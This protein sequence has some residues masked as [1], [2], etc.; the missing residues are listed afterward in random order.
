ML[1][2][3]PCF[4]GRSQHD[5]SCGWHYTRDLHMFI[6]QFSQRKRLC[7]RLRRSF[8]KNYGLWQTL[9][10]YPLLML[11]VS[12]DT[13]PSEIVLP[14]CWINSQ[15]CSNCFL[16]RY[17]V[18]PKALTGSYSPPLGSLKGSQGAQE[19]GWKPGFISAHGWKCN[20]EKDFND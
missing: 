3:N 19:E 7:K 2:I 8:M 11:F 13:S 17:T 6:S 10:V 4:H 20:V 1:Q 18:I 15:V 5:G 9:H 16:S 14:S 12:C